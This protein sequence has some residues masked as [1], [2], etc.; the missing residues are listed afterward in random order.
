MPDSH[1]SPAVSATTASAAA[2]S[3]PFRLGI[4]PRL[5][6]AFLAVTV[7]AIAANLLAEHGTSMLETSRS[8]THNP[9]PASGAR[10]APSSENPQAAV[11]T[12]GTA[13]FL[14]ALTVADRAVRERIDVNNP[15]SVSALDSALRVLSE[16]TGLYSQTVGDDR[17]R[18]RQTL[19]RRT[20]TYRGAAAVAIQL[21]DTRR[22]LLVAYRARLDSL[23]AA[24][25]GAIDR[26]WKLFGRLIAREYLIRLGRNFEA[27]RQSSVAVTSRLDHDAPSLNALVADEAAFES[28][29][30]EN[31]SAL[32]HSQGAQWETRVRNDVD[33]LIADRSAALVAGEQLQSAIA[34]LRPRASAAVR[35]RD[36]GDDRAVGFPCGVRAAFGH[37]AGATRSGA[38]PDSRRAT[39]GWLRVTVR[40]ESGRRA[41]ASVGGV[42][43]SHRAGIDARN[44]H[45]DDPQHRTAGTAPGGGDTTAEHG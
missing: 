41:G 43:H 27:M 23:D 31:G 34:R 9:A 5:G 10:S 32:R 28:I 39:A 6:F 25:K 15:G 12:S 26:S 16:S 4:A 33:G 3:R 36:G 40:P 7:L 8:S 11:T 21:A 38:N 30:S 17:R 45:L 29:L 13:D 22:D 2:S 35:H 14:S 20:G 37:D 19:S 44:V 42:D 1:R 24:I 18:D